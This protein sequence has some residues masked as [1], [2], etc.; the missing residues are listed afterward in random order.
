MI[1]LSSRVAL[2]LAEDFTGTVE[3]DENGLLTVAF[4]CGGRGWLRAADLTELIETTTERGTIV[5]VGSKVAF[6]SS[7]SLTGTV[8]SIDEEGMVDLTEDGTRAHQQVPAEELIEV[9]D[10]EL[11]DDKSWPP[12][13]ME[14]KSGT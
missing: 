14:T 4:D 2:A 10:H 1:G 7:P 6:R 11:P 12:A 13:S 9:T 5:H 8:N 3:K